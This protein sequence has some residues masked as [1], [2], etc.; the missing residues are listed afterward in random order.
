MPKVPTA[1][2]VAGRPWRVI[3]VFAVP[4]LVG[5]VVQQLY[6]VTDAVVV[7]RALGV[8]ALAAVGATGSFLFLL[9]GF[10]WGTT[11]GFAIPTAQAF[12]AGDAR[13]VRRSVAV[14]TVLTA[15]VSLLVTVVAPLLAG[16]AL[17]LLRTPPELLPQATTFAVVTFLGAGTTM[18]STGCST[19]CSGRCS[20]S[21]GRSRG[22]G[23]PPCRPSPGRW[24]CAAGPEPPSRSAR[25]GA[26]TASSGATRSRGSPP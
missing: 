14:G 21:G 6:Q 23:T 9:M 16:P 17:R 15:A 13:A 3:L 26:T 19:S 12:G 24:S 20:C 25:R 11:S 10:A 1:P 7:G 5:N 18:S 2:L 4:L 8:D 22:S